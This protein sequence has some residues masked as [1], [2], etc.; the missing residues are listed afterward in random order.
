MVSRGWSRLLGSLANQQR[1]ALS[2]LFFR[3]G[4]PGQQAAVRMWSCRA[5]SLL[6]VWEVRLARFLGRS[7]L[8]SNAASGKSIEPQCWNCGRAMG[9]GRGDEFFCAHCRALQP[10]DPTR[11]YFS[12]MNWYRRR[13]LTGGRLRLPNPRDQGLGRRLRACNFQPARGN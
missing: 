2:S 10:P 8:S 7:L 4:N 11:D 1:A 6:C 12:L 13:D 5:R 3:S 9:A